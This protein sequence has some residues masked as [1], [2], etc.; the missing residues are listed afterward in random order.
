MDCGKHNCEEPCHSFCRA[1]SNLIWTEIHCNCGA[2]VLYPPLPCNTTRPPCDQPC[3]RSHDCDHTPK[4]PCHD[5]SQCPPCTEFV[6]KVCYC[7]NEVCSN[8]MCFKKGVSCGKFCMKKLSC[9]LHNC[10]KVCHENSCPTCVQKCT[11]PRTECEHACGLACHQAS[12][13]TCPRSL[14]KEIVK[15]YC[16]CEVKVETRECH[17]VSGVGKLQT[18]IDCMARRYCFNTTIE[19]NEIHEMAKYSL[20]HILECDEKCSREKRLKDLAEAFGDLDEK[21][22]TWVKYTDFLKSKAQTNQQFMLTVHD[23]LVELVN[24]F[25]KVFYLFE[26]KIRLF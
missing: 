6:E 15:V 25:K 5:E 8:V 12:S 16:D 11:K 24:D 4:H 3:N 22:A 17:E 14:C 19:L 20:Y 23:K 18:A 7:G 2:Q 21:S 26:K 10:Q 13:E 9:N 1:C